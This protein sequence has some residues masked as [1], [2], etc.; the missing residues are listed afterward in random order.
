K[1]LP[2][3][4]RGERQ[5]VIGLQVAGMSADMLRGF[6]L[7]YIAML[8]LLPLVRACLELWTGDPRFSRAAVV[9]GSTMVAAGGVWKLWHTTPG[10][11]WLLLGGLGG[12][13]AL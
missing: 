6:L 11:R 13:L 12:G 2:A 3:L 8:S 9:C 7:T 1:R 10:A 4:D 5:T